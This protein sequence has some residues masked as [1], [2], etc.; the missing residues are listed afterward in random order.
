MCSS[1]PAQLIKDATRTPFNV[2]RGIELRDFTLKQAEPLARE[3]GDEGE[4]LLTRILHWTDGHPYLT[5]MLCA[6]VAVK[7]RNGSAPEALVDSVVEDTLLSTGARQEENNLK[8]VADR[9]TQGTGDLHGVLRIYRDV[10]R[11]K[12]VPDV[13]ASPLHTSLR[14]S[15]VVKPDA[16]RLLRVRN[17]VY[18]RVFDE[19]W[20]RQKMPPRVSWMVA[21]AAAAVIAIAA[22]YALW[23]VLLFPQAYVDAL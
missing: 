12:S 8:Y 16:D 22:T 6:K 11:G 1:A 23:Y 3:L 15:G 2:G 18:R 5:Q 21:A 13:P 7:D 10:V 17:L 14:L 19:A 9:L 20:V 4:R